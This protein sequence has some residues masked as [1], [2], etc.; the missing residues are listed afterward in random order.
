[1]ENDTRVLRPRQTRLLTKLFEVCEKGSLG[2]PKPNTRYLCI[3]R[4]D[5]T[6]WCTKPGKELALVGYATRSEGFNHLW[7]ELGVCDECF[8]A[9][10]TPALEVD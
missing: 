1:M 2:K 7:F 5:Y 8:K 4:N 3:G 9:L 10:G 6:H